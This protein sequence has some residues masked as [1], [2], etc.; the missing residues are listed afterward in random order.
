[1]G[2]I[3]KIRQQE[4]LRSRQLAQQHVA[5]QASEVREAGRVNNGKTHRALLAQQYRQQ[6]GVEA[7]ID[8]LARYLEAPIPY[9]VPYDNGERLGTEIKYTSRGRRRLLGVD[10][11]KQADRDSVVDAVTWDGRVLSKKDY[12]SSS[13]TQSEYK[14]L[15][16][17]S[18]PDGTIIF[19][20][21][22]SWLPSSGGST[23]RLDDWRVF[24]REEIIAKALTRAFEHP[25]IRKATF[26][27]W[28]SPGFG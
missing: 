8:E 26:T 22:R 25:L 16:I 6:S 13:V 12:V 17:E 11:Y 27:G 18:C 24:N 7:A 19:N 5:T 20:G 28:V 21:G 14:L 3:E 1:M 4:E 10:E 15:V 2:Y 9:E 23:I